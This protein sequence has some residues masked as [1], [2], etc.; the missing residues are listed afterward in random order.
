[1]Q[2]VYAEFRRVFQQSGGKCRYGYFKPHRCGCPQEGAGCGGYAKGAQSRG[3]HRYDADWAIGRKPA[4]GVDR[5]AGHD[6]GGA[7]CPGERG[8]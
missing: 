4:F 3:H 8:V 5:E 6:D 2:D 7:A 1:M